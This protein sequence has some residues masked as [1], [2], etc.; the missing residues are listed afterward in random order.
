MA[1]YFENLPFDIQQIIY[2]KKHQAEIKE[3]FEIIHTFKNNF[4][5]KVSIKNWLDIVKKENE[6]SDWEIESEEDPFGLL[7]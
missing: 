2:Q 3:S 4:C 5:P 7:C 1:N 6:P